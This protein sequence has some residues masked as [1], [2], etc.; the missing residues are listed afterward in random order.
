MAGAVG[1]G[2]TSGEVLSPPVPPDK[3]LKQYME[4]IAYAAYSYGFV[5]IP[6]KWKI[7][8]VPGWPNFRHNP[9]EDSQDIANG[10]YPKNVRRVGNLV[11]FGR[12]NNVGIITGEASGVVVIDIDTENNGLE[13]WR[14]LVDKNTAGKGLDK[15]FTVQ[16]SSGGLHYYFKY[17]PDLA[18]LGNINRIYR[19][20]FDYRTNNGMVVFPGSFDQR[21]RQYK[22]LS[23]YESPPENPSV[24]AIY[25]SS[26]PKWLKT[27]LVM[28]RI[29]KES[30]HLDVTPQNIMAK[31]QQLQITL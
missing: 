19:Y 14:Q 25:I 17:T 15:T 30:K 3:T 28:D 13:L 20:P 29:V 16:T 22:I 1:F 26:M 11:N 5:P 24:K 2:S 21:N 18:N 10:L 31:A 8:S 23:G 7:P 12:A 9:V 27:L 6:I 4:E